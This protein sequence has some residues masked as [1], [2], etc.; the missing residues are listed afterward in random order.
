[1]ARYKGILAT[2]IVHV[3]NP[4]GGTLLTESSADPYYRAQYDA[5]WA[6][7]FRHYGLDPDKADVV[8][9]AS[10]LAK[11][12]VPGFK[13]VKRTQGTGSNPRAFDQWRQA[14][15]DVSRIRRESGVGVMPACKALARMR[16]RSVDARAK[17][18]KNLANDYYAFVRH[19]RRDLRGAAAKQIEEGLADFL[20]ASP[21]EPRS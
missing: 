21:A 19:Y 13:I 3:G 20:L 11:A 8:A 6:A 9:L 14:F 16:A 15:T 2:P 12:H 4:T 7:L 18:A 1:M 5:R 10:A 17:A